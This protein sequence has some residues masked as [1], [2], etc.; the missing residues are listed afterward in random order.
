MIYYNIITSA[1]VGYDTCQ[2]TW[3]PSIKSVCATVLVVILRV[4]KGRESFGGWEIWRKM[5]KYLYFLKEYFLENDKLMLVINK[6]FNFKIF[7]KVV[8]FLR[9]LKQHFVEND[10]NIIT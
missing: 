3:H 9:T 5:E 2:T 10:N 7:F 4:W 1:D 6:F 8:I